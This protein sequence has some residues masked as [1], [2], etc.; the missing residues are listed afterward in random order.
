MYDAAMS[1][2]ILKGVNIHGRVT[3]IRRRGYRWSWT[4]LLGA[5]KKKWN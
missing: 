1:N 2:Y 3:L 5:A 4:S